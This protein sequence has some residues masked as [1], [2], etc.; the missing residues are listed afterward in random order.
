MEGQIS[1]GT[2]SRDGSD[3]GPHFLVN[4]PSTYLTQCWWVPLLSL[5]INLPNTTCLTLA[6]PEYKLHATH[7]PLA[8]SSNAVPTPGVQPC[9]P[10]HLQHSWLNHNRR[11]HAAHTWDTPGA[12]GSGDQGGLHHWTSKDTF[13]IRRPLFRDWEM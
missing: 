13:Y 2:F 4:S 9:T 7:P 1:S 12:P 3:G 10:A 8:G 5:S 6:F 11:V